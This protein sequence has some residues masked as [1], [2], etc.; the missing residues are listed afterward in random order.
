[1]LEESAA[2]R[3]LLESVLARSAPPSAASTPHHGQRRRQTSQPSATGS[4]SA[5]AGGDVGQGCDVNRDCER[6]DQVY[7]HFAELENTAGSAMNLS[8]ALDCVAA[9]VEVI[10]SSM[11]GENDQPAGQ[12]PAHGPQT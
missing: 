12:G 6:I 1:M 9:A 5:C 11:H 2:T 7:K 3:A 10:A 4:L 8:S